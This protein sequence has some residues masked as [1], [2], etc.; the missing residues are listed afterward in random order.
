[1]LD[2]VLYNGDINTKLY[3]SANTIYQISIEQFLYKYTAFLYVSTKLI[4]RNIN[5]K[6]RSPHPCPQ[7]ASIVFGGYNMF[8][9][10]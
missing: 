9:N 8:T 10:M 2:I 3:L 7:G 5:I 4:Y 1:M 6:L